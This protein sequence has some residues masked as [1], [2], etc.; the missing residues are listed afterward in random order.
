MTGVA[1]YFRLWFALGRFGLLR[2]MAFRSNFLVRLSVEV[3]WFVVMLIFYDVIFTQTGGEAVAGWGRYEYYFFVGCYFALGGRIE[4][5]FLSN[6]GQFAG[7]VRS[8][9]LDF[10][11]LTPTDQ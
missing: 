11:L 1:R 6:C 3:I 10:C 7:L 5:L 8:G 9:N 4:P 2:E